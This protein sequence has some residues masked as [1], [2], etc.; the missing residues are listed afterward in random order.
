MEFVDVF[1][2]HK[3]V[4][5]YKFYNPKSR[6]RSRWISRSPKYSGI[7]KSTKNH[8]ISSS[9]PGYSRYAPLY[10]ESSVSDNQPYTII[11]QLPKRQEK[12]KNRYYERYYDRDDDVHDREYI[13]DYSDHYEDFDS[14]AFHIGEK[15]VRIKVTEGADSKVQIKISRID[16]DKGIE[17][18]DKNN[19]SVLTTPIYSNSGLLST[20]NA[21][22]N[23]LPS[24]PP[25][26]FQ[27]QIQ[28]V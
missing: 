6:H 21:E 1:E 10:E 13:G 14:R 12:R 5:P 25:L 20:R 16:H 26:F 9:R 18:I 22:G 27:R 15:K 7:K 3:Y 23:W 2:I 19:T 17:I 11:I 4:R 28:R 24:E 8:Y